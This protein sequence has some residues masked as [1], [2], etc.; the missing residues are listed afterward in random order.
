M[1]IMRLGLRIM[2]FCFAMVFDIITAPVRIWLQ[3]HQWL[4]KKSI[5]AEMW[6]DKI[7]YTIGYLIVGVLPFLFVMIY[8]HFLFG[9]IEDKD[10]K[11][12]CH[13]L[14]GLLVGVSGVSGMIAFLMMRLEDIEDSGDD[15]INFFSWTTGKCL[16]LFN[17]KKEKETREL[18]FETNR[19]RKDYE[20]AMRKLNKE[21]PGME[22]YENKRTGS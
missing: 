16:S 7:I 11:D 4:V 1:K 9:R 20:K 10:L 6:E 18:E 13:A 17:K 12:S 3:A 19:E 2:T 14:W 21:F 22:L 5:N 15:Q 8:P